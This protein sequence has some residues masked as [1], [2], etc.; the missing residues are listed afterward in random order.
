MCGFYVGIDLWVCNTHCASGIKY[1][2]EYVFRI[3]IIKVATGG[4]SAVL[5]D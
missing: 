1:D 4:Q 3:N 5:R 2:Y